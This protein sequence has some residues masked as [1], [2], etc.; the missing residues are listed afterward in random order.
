MMQKPQE[1]IH[2][3]VLHEEGAKA[4][5]SLEQKLEDGSGELG[6]I[7]QAEAFQ[8]DTIG[9]ESLDVGVIDERDPIQVHDPEI[10]DGGFELVDV[11][12]LIDLGFLFLHCLF[13]RADQVQDFQSIDEVVNLPHEA[14]HE[15]DFGQADAH[16]PQL[17]REGVKVIEIMQL[18]RRRE[19]Q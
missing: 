18:H 10:G 5:A 8:G 19:I 13:V 4:L 14:F 15:D 6:T 1:E 7:G 9:G 3:S 16:R 17:G 11:D 12:D 2:T